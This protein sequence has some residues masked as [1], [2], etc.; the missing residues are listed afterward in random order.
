MIATAFLFPLCSKLLTLDSVSG[1][2]TGK[3]VNRKPGFSQK[4]MAPGGGAMKEEFDRGLCIERLLT[5]PG[6][7][8]STL[9]L[10]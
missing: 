9:V 1:T 4:K 10:C 6:S 8:S 3:G 7:A 5:A 2:S